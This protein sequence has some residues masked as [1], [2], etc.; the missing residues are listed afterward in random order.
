MS[1]KTA[2]LIH[3]GAVSNIKDAYF[4]EG[5]PLNADRVIYLPLYQDKKRKKNL[6]SDTK[7]YI[8]EE[9]VPALEKHKVEI[10]LIGDADYFKVFTGSKTAEAFLG[11][12]LDSVYGE[13]KCFYI[14]NFKSKFYDP[15]NVGYKIGLVLDQYDD[16][17]NDAYSDPG[18][19]IIKHSMFPTSTE[20]IKKALDYLLELDQPLACDIES[21]SLRHIDAGIG[22]I[23]FSWDKEGGI[24]FPVDFVTNH[25]PNE[26]VREL[27]RDFF[28]KFENKIYFHRITYDVYVLVYQLFMK[29]SIDT[30]GLLNGLDVL[31]KNW[32]CTYLISYLANNSCTRPDLSL[33]SLAQPFAGNWAIESDAIKD[34]RTVKLNNLLKYNLIDTMSTV[35]VMETFHPIMVEDDQEEIYNTIFKPAVFDI[36][37]MQ[38]TGLPLNMEKVIEAKEQLSSYTTETLEILNDS[39]FVKQLVEQL[40]IEYAEMKNATYVKKRITPEEANQQFNPNSPLQLQKLLYEVMELPVIELTKSKAPATGGKVITTLAKNIATDDPIMTATL[41][42]L[43]EYKSVNKILTGFI[44]AMESAHKAEDGWHYLYG[45]FNLGGTV[46]GRLSSSDPNLQNLPANGKLAEIIKKCFQAPPGW[47]F[48]GLDYSSL[49]DRISALTT[50]DPNKLKVYTDGYEGHSFRAYYYWQDKF[51]DIDPNSVESIN[52]IKDK[53]PAERSKSKTPTFLLTYQGTSKGLQQ[54]CGFSAE[55]ADRIEY[56][57]KNVLYKTSFDWVN[58]K[59]QKAT[60]DG[61]VTGAFGLR[62]RTPLLKQVILGTKHTPFEAEAEARTA[63]NAL[64]QS[65]CLLNSRSSSVFMDQVRNHSKYRSY[66]RICAQIHDAS[67]YMIPDDVGVASY[68][69]DRLVEAV[70]WNDHPDIY[71]PE[72]GLGGELSIFYPTWNDE[73]VIPNGVFNDDL[74]KHINSYKKEQ[75]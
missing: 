71:H 48:I 20:D 66:I 23:A 34:I 43:A 22:S 31:L 8:S 3:D 75:Q 54:K 32:D 51:P 26:E 12:A 38:L 33:K 57:F 69:N 64:G 52:S 16:Y 18:A 44:P 70:N 72:V 30:E 40:N 63:G 55:E 67:Y 37:Q 15:D 13:Y 27:L 4:Y 14:P 62:V 47:L 60:V 7:Q 24:A 25:E 28:I 19:D 35:Y 1:K 21:Y 59:I 46:S 50:K 58:S 56:T 65:W 5:T 73:I 39:P 9:I 68:V 49:E 42:A 6:V 74:V 53:Y 17:V 29:T 61:Y 45:F 36:I 10:V 2:L 11:Y 41:N